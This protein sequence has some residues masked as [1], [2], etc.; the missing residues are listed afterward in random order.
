MGPPVPQGPTDT[1]RGSRPA[2]LS[3]PNDTPSAELPPPFFLGE[4]GPWLNRRSAAI[5]PCSLIKYDR[6]CMVS[7]YLYSSQ[8]KI[9]QS[10]LHVALSLISSFFHISPQLSDKVLSTRRT[11]RRQL[12]QNF[13]LSCFP[14]LQYIEPDLVRSVHDGS[15]GFSTF[16]FLASSLLVAPKRL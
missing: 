13:P 14:S 5:S 1:F 6:G 9:P 16:A 3:A 12:P 11:I 10:K 4:I 7:V 2:P 8:N 15:I